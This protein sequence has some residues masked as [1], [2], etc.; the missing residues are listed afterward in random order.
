M[1][2]E[3]RQADRVY[4]QLNARW[5]GVLAR[6]EGHV[7]D[8]STTGCF[9]LTADLVKPK[10]LIRVEIQLPTEGWLYLWGEVVYRIEEMGFALRFTGVSDMEQAMLDLLLEFMREES[11][12]NA[13]APALAAS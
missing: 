6:C 5:E 3:R 7:V 8:L 11:G 12:N 2:A 13:A 10:E 4:V 1:G 9:V